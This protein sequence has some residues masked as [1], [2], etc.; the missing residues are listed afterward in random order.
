LSESPEF[1]HT[2][3]LIV[4]NDKAIAPGGRR[5]TFNKS[6]HKGG[7]WFRMC[8]TFYLKNVRSVGSDNGI[9]RMKG[10]PSE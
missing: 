1:S 10:I 9:L 2:D 6:I 8:I 4:D 5:R 3:F 7:R